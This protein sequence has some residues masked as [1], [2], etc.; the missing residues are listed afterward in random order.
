MAEQNDG[1][2]DP[3]DDQQ[4]K[5]KLTPLQ[6]EVTRNKATEQAFTGEY[7]NTTDDGVYKLSLIH[8]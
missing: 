6:F 5:D 1:G 2:I 3:R 7:W 4:Y 8:I